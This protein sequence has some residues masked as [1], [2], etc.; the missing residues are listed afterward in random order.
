MGVRGDVH[1]AGAGGAQGDL[2]G[3][4]AR[5]WVQLQLYTSGLQDGGGCF[6]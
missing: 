6:G 3:G 4:I 1:P 2:H 5:G